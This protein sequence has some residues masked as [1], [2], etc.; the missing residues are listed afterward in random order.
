MQFKNIESNIEVNKKNQ[1]KVV[2]AMK[3]FNTV[4]NEANKHAVPGEEWNSQISI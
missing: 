4:V 1:K 3:K 2:S